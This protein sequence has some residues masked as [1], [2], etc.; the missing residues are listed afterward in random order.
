MER[1]SGAGSR[2]QQTKQGRPDFLLPRH[3]LQLF[4]GNTEAFPGQPRDIVPSAYPGS[5]PGPPPGWICPE[6]L[7]REA[8]RRH[9]EQT[10]NPPQL[11]PLNVE[12]QRL[13]S[14]LLSSDRAPHPI[15]K[16]SGILSFWS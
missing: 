1:L 14:E 9:P 6:H 12:E 2:G 11:T 7:P 3:V 13:Y 15:S 8:S 4:R 5:T 16:G 10:Q